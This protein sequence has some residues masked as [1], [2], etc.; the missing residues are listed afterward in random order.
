M[1]AS[2]T[3]D[4][5]GDSIPDRLQPEIATLAWVN[6]INFDNAVQGNFDD[7][8]KTSIITIQSINLDNQLN[9]GSALTDISVIPF[10][11]VEAGAPKDVF[12]D[13]T[14]INFR[15]VPK[16]S[17]GE[18]QDIDINRSGTQIKISIDISQAKLP[19][20]YFDSYYSYISSEVINNYLDA[21][22]E[23]RTLDG[24][25]LSR[26]DQAGW[27]NYT[28]T[29]EGGDGA[30]YTVKN[31]IIQTVEIIFTDNQFGDNDPS[32]NA[33]A[34]PS[35]PTLQPKP[36]LEPKTDSQLIGDRKTANN[37][38]IIN[39]LGSVNQA[40]N[41]QI[42]GAKGQPLQT[43]SNY[44]I[45]EVAIDGFRSIYEFKLLD[46]NTRQS[47]KQPFGKYYKGLTTENRGNVSDGNY[48]VEL[49]GIAT[50]SFRI[51][52][53]KL[54]TH[55]RQQYNS[56]ATGNKD[57]SS[58][59][60]GYRTEQTVGSNGDDIL[61][62]DATSN[63]IRG[64]KGSDLINGYGNRV[65]DQGFADKSGSTQVDLLTG[66]KGSDY[67][68][69]ADLLGSFYAGNQ[70]NDYALITDFEKVDYII[71]S[72]NGTDYN[73]NEVSI[74]GQSGIGI[75]QGDDLIALIQGRAA[76]SFAFDDPNQVIFI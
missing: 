60:N 49:N 61:T 48:S 56:N 69:L 55:K 1:I 15:V 28:Q 3:N 70:N 6:N 50:G 39:L 40:S 22:L 34:D 52:T 64:L 33:V 32:L 8:P 65:T 17:G 27:Y 36:R 68:Q 46:A 73:S 67:F 58:L 72:S 51:R 76:S 19:A 63:E 4:V 62:G 7:V 37:Y 74:D 29:A 2:E 54:S 18:L 21:G 10:T 23:L 30:R 12:I 57:Y 53:N 59:L 24:E 66:G 35:I 25:L 43:G 20:S 38:P 42:T 75:Y 5:N 71:L 41:L 14:P 9:Q 11:E 16:I 31:G 47:G 45:K 13:W 44:T 26:P